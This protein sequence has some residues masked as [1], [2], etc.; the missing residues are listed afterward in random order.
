MKISTKDCKAVEESLT[1]A[2][3]DIRANVNTV[4]VSPLA[5]TR[6]VLSGGISFID[7]D[8]ARVSRYRFPDLQERN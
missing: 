1:I 2:A 5:Y 4:L 3:I 6:N 8:E 7:V